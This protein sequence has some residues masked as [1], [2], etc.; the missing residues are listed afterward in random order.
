MLQQAHAVCMTSTI[1]QRELRND[2]GA[3]MCALDL[4]EVFLEPLP[5][6]AA[7]VR[8]YGL[9][10]AATRAQEREP[11]GARVVDPL[12]A[13]TALANDLPPFT[14]NPDDFDHLGGV[15]LAVRTV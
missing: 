4:G 3:I 2:S 14:R 13:A 9:V 1:S 12:I 11:R 6:D 5:F 15:G 7:A 10:D 8:A